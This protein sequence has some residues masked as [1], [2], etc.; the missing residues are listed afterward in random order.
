[1]IT[2]VSSCRPELLGSRSISSPTRCMLDLPSLSWEVPCCESPSVY[3]NEADRRYRSPVGI[4]LSALVWVVYTSAIQLE[5]YVHPP[6]EWQ[7]LIA[8]HSPT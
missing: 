8:D 2:L 1:V 6:Y 7:K 5:G 4:A 3:W